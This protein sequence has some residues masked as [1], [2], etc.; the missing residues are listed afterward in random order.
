MKK[1]LIYLKPYLK[2]CIIAPSAM[3]LEVILDLM[4]PKL[5]SV[6]IDDGVAGGDINL[7]I[8]MGVIMLAV[9]FVS[10]ICG[11]TCTVFVGFTAQNFSCDLRSASFR[12]VMS[13]SLEQTDKF[14]SGSL[15]TRLTNDISVVQHFIE[16]AL[17][18]FVR[19]FSF[20]IGGIIMMTTLDLSFGTVIL[21]VL[22]A[23]LLVMALAL[24]KA[25]PVY[26]KVQ[27][28][29]DKVN[30]VVKENINGMR[31][32]KAFVRE[33]YEAGRFAGANND[34]ADTNLYV[35]I[36]I[37]TLNPVLTLINNIAIAAVILIGGFQVEARNIQAGEVMA[38]VTYCTQIM[39]AVT[40]VSMMFQ[41]VSRTRASA[42]RIKELLD[43]DPVLKDGDNDRAKLVKRGSVTFRNVNF[44][45]PES[46]GKKVLNGIS[47]E[48][49]PGESFAVLGST[50]SGKTTL[51]NLIS[52]FY[53]CTEGEILVDGIPVRDYPISDLRGKISMVLQK[54]ELF[55]GTVK[56]N[57]GIGCHEIS[58]GEVISAAKTA[59]AH[60][61]ISKIP[62]Q[63]ESII[64][65]KGASLSGGQKQRLC[66]A[67]AIAK[68]PEILILDDSTS[69]LDLGTEAKL[70]EALRSELKGTTVI[71]I[72]QR[73]ASVKDCDRI[74]V[75]EGGVLSAVGTHDELMTN[76][77]V[78]RDIYDSQHGGNKRFDDTPKWASTSRQWSVVSGQK[79]DFKKFNN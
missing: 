66:I 58:D 63:Y 3:V 40:M 16:M 38:A 37:A 44:S 69:A 73:I 67:R 68:K 39:M 61:F 1:L 24:F 62:G 36:I 20:F 55:S 27:D 13:L 4:L 43:T 15:I 45:Y 54:C 28:K 47:L 46:S 72:A 65:E 57:I 79:P 10:G 23:M 7:I 34:L 56:Y 22:P 25:L 35:L 26:A 53:D 50:G 71:K 31:V 76:S 52:R 17:R 33:K 74:A 30:N 77:Q 19:M 49:K 75:I 60:E 21:C 9:L 2:Y 18:M 51:V 5:M 42:S 11:L 59:Q 12:K 41:S 29:L 64:A 6:I 48:I 8:R 32:V 14:T 78:Y 70:Q